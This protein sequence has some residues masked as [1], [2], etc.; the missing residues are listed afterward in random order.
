M[1]VLCFAIFSF[2]YTI[3]QTVNV[4]FAWMGQIVLSSFMPSM[5]R[6]FIN[7]APMCYIKASHFP[8]PRSHSSST[9][10]HLFSFPRF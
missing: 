7:G 1:E 10:P 2:L 9:I 3:R 6:A 5:G 4:T 8:P